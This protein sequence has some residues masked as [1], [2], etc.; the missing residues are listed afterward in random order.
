[1]PTCFDRAPESSG[2]MSA[3]PV[4]SLPQS[5]STGDEY[6]WQINPFRG[7]RVHDI[8]RVIGVDPNLPTQLVEGIWEE[9]SPHA[10]EW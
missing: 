9:I 1:M 3:P 2:L 10:E 6:F 5:N 4:R 7:L 8:A